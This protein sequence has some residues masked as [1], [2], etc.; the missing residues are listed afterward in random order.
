MDAR[1]RFYKIT[2]CG[3]YDHSDFKFGG[4][5]DIIDNVKTWITDKALNETQ[6]Y[7]VDPDNNESDIL[8]TYCYSIISRSGEYLMT[9]WNE[10]SD[11]D[12]KV[13]SIDGLGIT[14]QATNQGVFPV[15]NFC[16]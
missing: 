12:G 5:A 8:R 14:G 1:I 7:S 2:Q 3:Y 16:R 6:T 13:A 4:I 15:G 10:N 11:V 9:T